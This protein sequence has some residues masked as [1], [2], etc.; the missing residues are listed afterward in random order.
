MV[1]RTLLYLVLLENQRLDLDGRNCKTSLYE[2]LGR[3]IKLK[4]T[5]WGIGMQHEIRE[6]REDGKAPHESETDSTGQARKL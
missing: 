1:I 2:G 5:I 3:C 6:L 4:V